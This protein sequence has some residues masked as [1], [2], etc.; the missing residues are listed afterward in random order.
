M[1]SDM[2]HLFS[3]SILSLVTIDFVRT[4]SSWQQSFF[5]TF[6]FWWFT[7][8]HRCAAIFVTI[9]SQYQPHLFTNSLVKYLHQRGGGEWQLSVVAVVLVATSWLDFLFRGN[10]MAAEGK[11]QADQLKLELTSEGEGYRSWQ[12]LIKM[13]IF[14]HNYLNI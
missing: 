5:V 10:A 4:I 9:D 3:C 13:T 7:F 12:R 2:E 14:C 11:W 8:R 6:H 1:S